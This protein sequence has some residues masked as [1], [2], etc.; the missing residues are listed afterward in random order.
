MIS[1]LAKLDRMGWVKG[2]GVVDDYLTSLERGKS[3]LIVVPTHQEG[4]RLTQQIRDRLK[5]DG[6]VTDE[7]VVRRLRPL[8]YSQA[9]LREAKTA[10]PEDGVLLIKFAAY[11]EETQTLG[12]GDVVRATVPLKD[13]AGRTIETGTVMT[14]PVGPPPGT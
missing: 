7:R 13:M 12:V 11:R 8:N 4:E 1:A 6:K 10:P 14:R 2:S 5:A 9:E 3:A